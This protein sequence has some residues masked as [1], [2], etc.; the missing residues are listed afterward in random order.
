MGVLEDNKALIR[1][2]FDAIW[3]GDDA[4]L[5]AQLGAGFIDHAAQPGS[6]KGIDAVIEMAR[7]MRAVFPDMSVTIDQSVAE[8]DRVAVYATWRGTHRAP[9]LGVAATN[10]TISF[11]GMVFW[12]IVDG[13]I[14]GRWATLDLASVMRQ[15]QS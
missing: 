6:P 9:F 12:R 10:K 13:K 15:L 4:A 8:G 5:R 11:T 1:A 3:S 14:V 2:H 7:G